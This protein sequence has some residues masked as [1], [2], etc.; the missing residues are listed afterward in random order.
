[1]YVGC[2]AYADDISLI[3]PSREALQEMINICSSYFNEHGIK[4][5]TNQDI[6]KT[7]TKILVFGVNNIPANIILNDRPLPYVESWYHLGHVIHSDESTIHDIDEKRR[8]FIGKI[9]SF[10]Q[11]F[12]NQHPSV[13]FK[14]VFSYFLHFYGSNL[15]DLHC[16]QIEKL[17]SCWHKTIKSAFDL[18]FATHRYLLQ[19]LV[20]YKHIR[21][22][23]IKRFINF[24]KKIKLSDNPYV[25]MIF[26]VQSSDYRSTFGKNILSLCRHARVRN[27]EDADICVF[28]AFPVPEDERWRI[29]LIKDLIEEN[30]NP[31]NLLTRDELELLMHT[32]CCL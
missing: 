9:H 14:L 10:R 5:S 1:M 15:W 19:D 6:R 17:W 24:Y 32:V 11:E 4:I 25:K 3:A 21:T 13:F 30:L 27:L 16:V 31:S 29:P 28:D 20:P 2:Y 7:K 8:E 26:K 23:I 22:I 18:P 12:G